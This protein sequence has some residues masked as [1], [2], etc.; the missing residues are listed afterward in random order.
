MKESEPRLG[1][2]VMCSIEILLGPIHSG[3]TT[4]IIQ[5][6]V[7]FVRRGLT[8]R[9][10]LVLPTRKKAAQTKGT[11]LLDY[12]VPGLLSPRI[13]TFED[14]VQLI[15]ESA[16]HPATGIS[17][18]ER[19]SLIERILTDMGEAGELNYFKNVSRFPGF[20][21]VIGQLISE[22]KSYEI[23]PE[24][25]FNVFKKHSASYK[26]REVAAIY[27]RYQRELHERNLYDKQG[28]YW[29]A[30]E[31]L[32]TEGC[33][34]L[35]QVELVMID[36][37]H[38]FTPA[39]LTLVQE[40]AKVVPR[41]L[42]SLDHEQTPDRPNLF[43]AADRTLQVLKRRFPY[44]KETVIEAAHSDSTISMLERGI[45]REAKQRQNVNV[46]A[47]GAIEIIE[48]P[49]ELREVEEIAREAKRLLHNRR[50]EPDDIGV[51]F[52]TLDVYGPLVRETFRDYGLPCSVAR[53]ESLSRSPVV[54]TILNAIA[55]RE[56]DWERDTV[57]GL[58]KSNYVR[59]ANGWSETV[60][61]LV[62]HWART[63]GIVR[64]KT[65]WL[66]Q[67]ARLRESF[68]SGVESLEEDQVLSEE[69]QHL[70]EQERRRQIT[71]LD[72][73]MA[74]V[75]EL[76][77]VIELMPDSG[78][79]RDYVHALR[80]VVERLG[81]R[82]AVLTATDLELLRRDLV[83]YDRFLEVLDEIERAETTRDER[84]KPLAEFLASVTHALDRI[85]VAEPGATEGKIKVLD[86]YQARHYRFPVVFLGGLVEKVFPRQHDQ[87]PLY[88]D[89]A[90]RELGRLGIDLQER[91]T[92]HAEEIF[93]FYNA[94]TRATE[95]MYFTYSLTDAKGRSRMRSFYL[96]EVT[97][98]L[99]NS[100]KPKQFPY[101]EPVP[102]PDDI[103]NSSDLGQWLFNALWTREHKSEDRQAART[104]YN[105]AA[106]T[107][108]QRMHRSILNAFMEEK[109]QYAEEHD[110]YDGVLSSKTVLREIAERFP[111]DY[112]F[113]PTAL[114]DYGCCPFL[115]FCKKVLHLEPQ[116]EPEEMIAAVDRGTLY[117][118]ILWR[119]YAE[120]RDQRN[121]QT[122]FS[123][124]ERDTMLAHLIRIAHEDFVR[125]EKTG[126]I[127]NPSLWEIEKRRTE[128]NLERFLDHELKLLNEM[129]E[130]RPAHFELSFGLEKPTP[131]HDPNSA[132]EPL[133]IDSV[134]LGGKIDRVDILEGKNECIVID[135][136][137]GGAATSW[138]QVASGLSF[139]LP[140]YWLAC[141][142]LLF[143]DSGLKCV[144]ALF[145]RLCG[146]YTRALNGLRRTN[147]DW[148][149]SLN[150]CREQIKN[151]T[152][153]IRAG[154]FP[155]MPSER[156][157][158]WCDYKEMC[159]YETGRIE[160]K[161]A[162]PDYRET[163]G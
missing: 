115:Y 23:E 94:I 103:W 30:T 70:Q 66:G 162:T 3:K 154:R 42:F 53:G 27:A 102:K 51:I 137:T 47:D 130:R 61:E 1:K 141:E 54:K 31:L 40:M 111:P 63:A 108:I 21:E 105:R 55:V 155:V 41:I 24:R 101:S 160:R 142:E 7:S 90:R 82:K 77:N 126:F 81:I 95:K 119:F 20:V 152:E 2:A 72:E 157:V 116:E 151:C 156:C 89:P 46:S 73:V 50:Y 150:Q 161:R 87:D 104:L 16:H 52:R 136:K 147:K 138:T 43:A 135:Y 62:E 92:G 76:Q 19:Y 114:N 85:A 25:F 69:E 75:R 8:D 71:E 125:H 59:L 84:T 65:K 57:I 120:L 140:V 79:I 13:F 144:E 17:D 110:D 10:V 80:E 132:R 64:T 98:I 143:R 109:R 5:E 26:D 159:R 12:Q 117:H 113:S 93:L 146:D 139:Q 133:V 18:I 14:V 91:N 78:T 86:V 112:R 134:C 127:G 49:S 28:G 11:L 37:F 153:N 96:D 29:I 9:A 121:G 100:A 128:R 158:A 123:E 145:Y 163:T 48:A 6:Y 4:R 15:L 99:K 107:N 131:P 74:L 44:I 148:E 38:T 60:P 33:S 32:R 35:E 129:P 122:R 118:R 88:N 58:V 106:T 67:F 34:Q 56:T 39:E 36:G 149:S 22:L 83:A 45:F 68:I 97:S 124:E